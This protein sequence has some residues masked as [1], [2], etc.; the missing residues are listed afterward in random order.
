MLS[1]END[2]GALAGQR[3]LVLKEHLNVGQTGGHQIRPQRRNTAF[4]RA[5]LTRG[6]S[7]SGPDCHL[8]SNEVGEVILDSRKAADR[9]AIQRH[10]T[11]PQAARSVSCGWGHLLRR[12]PDGP[13]LCWRLYPS[14]RRAAGETA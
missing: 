14:G 3:E 7:A 8:L 4:P 2:V 12:K 9:L 10:R 1:R 5:V 6:R 13:Q 11:E